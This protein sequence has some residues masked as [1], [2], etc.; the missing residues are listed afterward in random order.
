M[1]LLNGYRILGRLV[2]IGLDGEG[3]LHITLKPSSRVWAEASARFL[4]SYEGSILKFKV[5]AWRNSG[6]RSETKRHSKV[7]KASQSNTPLRRERDV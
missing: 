3:N 4:K 6:K 7:L 2:Y 1:P 5:E